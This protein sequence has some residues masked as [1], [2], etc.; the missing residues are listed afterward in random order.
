MNL[1]YRQ[2]S[3]ANLIPSPWRTGQVSAEA[4]RLVLFV[5][6]ACLKWKI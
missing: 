1:K 5:S 6:N 3:K 2:V 4:E